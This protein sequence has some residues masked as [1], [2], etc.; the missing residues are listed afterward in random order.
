MEP[1][2]ETSKTYIIILVIIGVLACAFASLGFMNPPDA[3]A[4]TCTT[5]CT[6][7]HYDDGAVRSCTTRCD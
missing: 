7:T 3:A 5:T 4:G 1:E 2:T 6:T